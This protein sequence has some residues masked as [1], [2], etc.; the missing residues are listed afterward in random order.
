VK[1]KFKSPKKKLL[2]YNINR[3]IRDAEDILNR[4]VFG[5]DLGMSLA[6]RKTEGQEKQ[7]ET[8]KKVMADFKTKQSQAASENGEFVIWQPH[9]ISDEALLSLRNLKA[10]CSL[11]GKI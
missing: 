5:D 8:F 1:K 2:F 6:W 9:Q 7:L 3:K 4:A 10:K 11:C